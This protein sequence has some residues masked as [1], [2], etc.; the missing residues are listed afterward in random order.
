[1]FHAVLGPWSVGTLLQDGTGTGTGTA[2][3][4]GVVV[5]KC[6]YMLM[7][8]GVAVGPGQSI[9]QFPIVK[10]RMLHLLLHTFIVNIV[11]TKNTIVWDVAP[12]GS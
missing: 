8:D 11:N 4:R 12:G 10:R 1:M 3:R 9:S 5:H 2:C 6:V 7:H